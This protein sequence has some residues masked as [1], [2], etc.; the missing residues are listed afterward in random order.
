MTVSPFEAPVQRPSDTSATAPTLVVPAVPRARRRPRGPQAV[1]AVMPEILV[2]CV[3]CRE[4]IPTASFSTVATDPRLT[5]ASCPNCGLLVSATHA[6][7]AYWNRPSNVEPERGR[8]EMLR[9]RRVAVATRLLRERLAVTRPF[10][11]I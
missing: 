6:T 5:S 9:A 2:P 8:S 4:G 1:A 11:V 3:F 10:E 7:W